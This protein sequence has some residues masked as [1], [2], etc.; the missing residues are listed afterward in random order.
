MVYDS[1]GWFPL[2]SVR[3]EWP[4]FVGPDRRERGGGGGLVLGWKILRNVD[5][6]ATR[7]PVVQ[8]SVQSIARRPHE[9][10]LELV[11]I[12]EQQQVDYETRL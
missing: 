4:K 7:S 6:G 2:D 10:S 11:L 9:T 1:N 8:G 5:D 3:Y 12:P